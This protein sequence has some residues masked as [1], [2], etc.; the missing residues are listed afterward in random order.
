LKITVS[1]GSV[2]KTVFA[3]IKSKYSPDQ[4]VGKHVV[5]V[6]NL[7]PRKMKFGLSEGMLL[8]ASDES[9]GPFLLTVDDGAK[10]GFKIK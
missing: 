3:G 1:V 7:Q 10:E 2:E 6:N 8:A 4:L 5:L 9:S